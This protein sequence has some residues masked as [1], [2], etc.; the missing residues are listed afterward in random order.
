MIVKLVVQ[1]MLKGCISWKRLTYNTHTIQLDNAISIEK[2][3]CSW[4]SLKTSTF[5]LLKI[6]SYILKTYHQ[7]HALNLLR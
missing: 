3:N 5:Y 2:Q 1:D 4:W 7:I 6:K